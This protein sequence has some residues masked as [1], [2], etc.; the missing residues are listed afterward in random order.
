M[1]SVRQKK[2]SIIWYC[3]HVESKEV[4]VVLFLKR[5]DELHNHI[6]LIRRCTVS[7]VL[8]SVKWEHGLHAAWMF[9]AVSLFSVPTP[10]FPLA[11]SP[12]QTSQ[13]LL[14]SHCPTIKGI[15]WCFLVPHA[16]PLEIPLLFISC[17]RRSHL[18]KV[19]YWWLSISPRG[20]HDPLESL[21]IR[22]V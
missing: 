20:F 3:L 8:A 6:S 4:V 16:Y 10:E 18:L 15:G 2:T 5:Y 21:C 7:Y 13:K 12:K 17:V 11:S 14:L 1:K 19:S 22:H 9:N